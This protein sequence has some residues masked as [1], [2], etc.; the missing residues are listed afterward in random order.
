[1]KRLLVAVAALASVLALADRIDVWSAAS[2]TVYK[3]EL[4][5]LADGG[6]SVTA[7]ASYSKADGGQVSEG[8]ATTEVAG[9]NRVTC[10]DILNNKAPL[11]FKTDRGL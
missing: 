3:T 4:H 7:W 5:L 11:L 10:L 6:C 9:A 8:S 2:V 1:M